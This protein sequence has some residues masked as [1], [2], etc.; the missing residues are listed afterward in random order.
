MGSTYHDQ[1]DFAVS[2]VMMS[3]DHLEIPMLNHDNCPGL[4]LCMS[5]LPY[6][7]EISKK[8]RYVCGLAGL[9]DPSPGKFSFSRI[10]LMITNDVRHDRGM[11]GDLIWHRHL[12]VALRY[13][14]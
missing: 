5:P 2:K 11:N 4:C 13:N 14:P 3:Q 9:K 7:L 8:W 1:Y 10:F 6:Y 12:S